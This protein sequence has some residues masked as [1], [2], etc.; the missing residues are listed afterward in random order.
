MEEQTV[1]VLVQ[2]V[3]ANGTVQPT[4]DIGKSDVP[5]RG[6]VIGA[7][8]WPGLVFLVVVI[9]LVGRLLLS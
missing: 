1:L 4:H 9:L 6:I 8:R 3:E 7:S 5:D 2:I